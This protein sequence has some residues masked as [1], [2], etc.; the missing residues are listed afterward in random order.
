MAEGTTGQAQPETPLKKPVFIIGPNERLSF[1]VGEST[2]YY[3]RLTPSKHTELRSAHTERGLFN[4]QARHNFLVDMATYALSGW[5]NVRDGHMQPV[6]FLPEVIPYLPWAVLE[7]LDQVVLHESPDELVERYQRFLT[8][9]SPLSPPPQE[10]P[11][12]V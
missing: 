6:P 9:A 12:P 11:L 10:N 8:D 2:F 4:E 5:E 3:R 7:R 1:T